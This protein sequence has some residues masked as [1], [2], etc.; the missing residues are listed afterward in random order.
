[1]C[2][3]GQFYPKFKFYFPLIKTYYHTLLYKKKTEEKNDIE[4]QHIFQ[5][6]LVIVSQ[7][8]LTNMFTFLSQKC[9]LM[10]SEPRC[11]NFTCF[12]G[13]AFKGY[14]VY[15]PNLNL[16]LNLAMTSSI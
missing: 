16:N 14:C 3:V 1:M 11:K 7:W 6:C 9:E 8:A 10:F 15:C 4:P 13:S 5:L 12:S 2:V